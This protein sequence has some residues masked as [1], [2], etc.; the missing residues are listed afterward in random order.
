MV[1]CGGELV[2]YSSGGEGQ[3]GGGDE[4]VVVVVVVF[5]CVTESGG[6]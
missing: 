1:V 2:E 4:V 3:G 6:V 5:R